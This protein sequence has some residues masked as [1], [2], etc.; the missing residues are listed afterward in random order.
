MPAYNES[1]CIEQVIKGWISILDTPGI[2][3]GRIVVVNDGS[4]DDTGRILDSVAA[5]EP[6]LKVVHQPNGGHG[7]ALMNAY[8]QGIELGAEWIFHVDSDDQFETEDFFLL[9]NARSSSNFVMGRRL[10]RADPLH[11]LVITRILKW[12]N[13]FAFGKYV[14]DANNP[15]RLI[16]ASYLKALISV[17]PAGVFAPNIFLA[18]TAA[19]DGQ[20]LKSI[21]VRH[22]DRQTGKVSIVR[23]KLLKVCFRTAQELVEYRSGLKGRLQKLRELTGRA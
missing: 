6:R 20:D 1:G 16:K 18:V 13:F 7:N 2:E 3:G 21:P 11:R 4:K 23:L 10:N 5:R 9:W 22:K 12:L 15:F 8:S 14:P 19:L 17:I